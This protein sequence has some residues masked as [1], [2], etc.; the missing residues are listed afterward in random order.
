MLELKFPTF[1]H[2]TDCSKPCIIQT[3][4]GPKYKF[5]QHF[6]FQSPWAPF[7]NL[8]LNSLCGRLL[9]LPGNFPERTDGL[10]HW[11]I[12]TQVKTHLTTATRCKL[13]KQ[14]N[15]K[16]PKLKRSHSLQPRK[17]Y[18][19]T[20]ACVLCLSQGVAHFGE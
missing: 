20:Q 17:G 3:L 2:S 19:S 18:F 7:V 4:Y 12:Y 9:L 13:S 11:I 15:F 6:F 14:I 10:S 1:H 8:E 5:K 16:K